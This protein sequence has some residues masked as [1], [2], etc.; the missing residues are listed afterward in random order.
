MQK[1]SNIR[2]KPQEKKATFNQEPSRFWLK[3]P[4][5]KFSDMDWG[6][7]YLHETWGKCTHDNKDGL[8]PK[9]VFCVTELHKSLQSLELLTWTEIIE[10]DKAG[11]HPI[12]LADLEQVNREAGKRLRDKYS[13]KL[14]NEQ[15]SVICSIRLGSKK[16]VYGFIDKETGVFS[17]LWWDPNHRIWPTEKR[18][19]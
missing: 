18:N 14:R 12:N 3:K 4:T 10:G 17:F 16:R 11:S 1:K 2:Q 8:F 5:W 9:P 6:F 7:S 15:T 13:V 19:T